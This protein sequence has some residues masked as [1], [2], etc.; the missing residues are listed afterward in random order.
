M[1]DTSTCSPETAERI[2]C[3]RVTAGDML[4][5]WRPGETAMIDPDEAARAGDKVLVRFAGGGL[6]LRRLVDQ[7]HATVT[8]ATYAPSP[9]AV[10]DRRDVAALQFVCSRFRLREAA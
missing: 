4:P 6:V 9:P 10:Y 8:L 5:P 2:Y 7:K 1:P 3:A